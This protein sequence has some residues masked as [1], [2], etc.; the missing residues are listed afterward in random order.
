MPRRALLIAAAAGAALAGCADT[1]LLDPTACCGAT[2]PATFDV[3][4]ATTAGPFTLHI[5]R[6]WAPL[7]VDRF[8]NMIQCG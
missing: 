4:V 6:R 1:P 5:E 3:K 7:G 2:S 8:Y